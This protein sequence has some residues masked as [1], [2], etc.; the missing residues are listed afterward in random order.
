MKNNS[1]MTFDFMSAGR[2]IFGIGVLKKLQDISFI[3]QKNILIF[4]GSPSKNTKRVH[5]ILDSIRI[6]Y[7]T[8]QIHGEPNLGMI[9]NARNAAKFADV[10]IAV[11]GGSVIDTGKAVSALITNAGEVSDYLEIVGQ[12][13]PLLKPSLP[14]IAI[15]TTSGTGSE[16]TKN[17]VI[18]IPEYR[19]KVSLR[20]EYLLPNVA[21]IDPELTISLPKQITAFSG[22][23]ALT[24]VIEPFVSNRANIFTDSLCK[25]AI[26]KASTALKLAYDNGKNIQAREDMAWVSVCGGIALAN[27]GLGAVHGFAG[28]IGGMFN[29]PHGAVCAKLLPSVVATNIN[30]S[31]LAGLSNTLEKFQEIASLVFDD[32]EVALDSLVHWLEELIKYLKIPGLSH[33][34]VT[35][36]DIPQI[37]E[38][39]QSS[40]SMKGNPI[41]LDENTLA[42]ILRECM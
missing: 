40:S 35:V 3:S 10:I 4:E 31:R 32:K 12:G 13:N 18:N 30:A 7:E 15:P 6:K 38:K 37:V 17:A 14:F 34:G 1:G 26:K 19:V 27:A 20:H 21:I 25:A 29:A 23:D 5:E 39:A 9:S 16:V 36:N 28:P 24:Q 2:I 41:K 22:M 11:G 42:A 33:W 8:Y